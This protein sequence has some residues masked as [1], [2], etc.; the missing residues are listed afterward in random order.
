[1]P[2]NSIISQPSTN[3]LNAAYRPVFFV[4]NASATDNTA[5]PPVIYCDIYLNN[6]FY[7]TY[8]NSQCKNSNAT[9]SDWEFDIEDVL[10]EYLGKFLGSN[11]GSDVLIANPIITKV[12]C[13][14]RSS[15]YDINGF[16]KPEGTPPQQGTNSQPPISGDGFESNI[17]WCINSTLQH[18][19]NQILTDHLNSFK[20]GEWNDNSFPLTHRKN[21]YYLCK[22][23]SDYFPILHDGCLSTLKLTA[24]LKDGTTVIKTIDLPQPPVNGKIFE[25]YG[26]QDLQTNV[27]K[28][29][30]T[31]TGDTQFGFAYRLNSGNI[32]YTNNKEVDYTLDWGDYKF[33]V[34]VMGECSQGEFTEYDFE[35]KDPSTLT[36]DAVITSFDITQD[37]DWTQFA[38]TFTGAA[39]TFFLYLDGQ[40][41]TTATSSPIR[42]IG[43]TEGDHSTSILPQCANGVGGEGEQKQFT[44]PS[45]LKPP[46]DG[47]LG[48]WSADNI[49]LDSNNQIQWFNDNKTIGTANPLLNMAGSGYSRSNI[50]NDS[51]GVY[52]EMVNSP[53]TPNID[54]LDN[55]SFTIIELST[56][57]QNSMVGT[58]MGRGR[59]GTMS[60]VSGEIATLYLSTNQSY[61]LQNSHGNNIIRGY[62]FNRELSVFNLYESSSTAKQTTTLPANATLRHSSYGFVLGGTPITTTDG[63]VA[64]LYPT[65]F[66]ELLVYTRAIS[67]TEM[68]QAI[69]YLKQKWNV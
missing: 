10:Q 28:I 3:S 69:N 54:L 13:K 22:Y 56:G 35:M 26:G 67:S 2:I 40:L 60:F 44:V 65:Y 4:V 27:A 45:K 20:T 34:A 61:Q 36:C 55:Q 57:I 9:D 18:E 33:E 37:G 48:W 19:D 58:I 39:T 52:A 31:A 30:W 66:R 16:I 11:G 68:D 59:G 23:A 64:Q 49:Q 46:T 29:K 47:L 51:H 15:G 53:Y 50:G 1:M 41:A 63:L 43:L 25:V 32:K 24:K 62:K 38:F 21:N 8:S 6:I 14:F 12:L 7:K 5:L 42:L 17:F